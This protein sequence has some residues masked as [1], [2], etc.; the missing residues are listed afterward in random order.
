M[1]NK[2]SETSSSSKSFREAK[3]VRDEAASSDAFGGQGHSRTARSLAAIVSDN[4]ET[5][6]AIG[7]EGKYGSGKTTVVDFTRQILESDENSQFCYRVFSFDL[8]SNQKE[9]L[10]RVYLEELLGWASSKDQDLL[11][12]WEAE[13]FQKKI[14]DRTVTIH[15]DRSQKFHWF[16]YLLLAIAPLIPLIVTWASPMAWNPI[17]NSVQLDAFGIIPTEH[18]MSSGRFAQLIFL[19]LYIS[20][21]VAIVGAYFWPSPSIEKAKEKPFYRRAGAAIAEASQPFKADKAQTETETQIIREEDPSTLEFQSLFR[22]I[23]G[24]IQSKKRGGNPVRLVLVFDNIDRLTVSRI[25]P[26]WAE[27]RSIFAAAAP[28]ASKSE[29]SVTAVVPYDQNLIDKAFSG[30]DDST[31]TA[32]AEL[33][34]KTFAAT[35]RVAPPISFDGREYFQSKLTESIGSEISDDE[36]WLVYRVFHLTRLHNAESSPQVITPRQMISFI[37]QFAV[38]WNE[39]RG[40]VPPGTLALYA[41]N[42]N[43][44]V[45]DPSILKSR[46]RLGPDIVSLISDQKWELNLS[47]IYYNVKT[48]HVVPLVM[49]GEIEQALTYG[50]EQERTALLNQTYFSD[51]LIEFVEEYVENFNDRETANY[52]NVLIG[53][54]SLSDKPFAYREARQSLLR[55]NPYGGTA[56]DMSPAAWG[57]LANRIEFSEHNNV[58]WEAEKWLTAANGGMLSEGGLGPDL[59]SR[60]D[61]AVPMLSE[62]KLAGLKSYCTRF[63]ENLDAPSSIRFIESVTRSENLD[64]TWCS[65]ASATFAESLATACVNQP[66]LVQTIAKDNPHWFDEKVA[67]AVAS[68]L[69]PA[70]SEHI[71]KSVEKSILFLQAV[72]TC[73]QADESSLELLAAARGKGDLVVLFNYAVQHEKFDTAAKSLALEALNSKSPQ[74]EAYPNRTIGELGTVTDAVAKYNEIVN[75]ASEDPS[76]LAANLADLIWSENQAVTVQNLASKSSSGSIFRKW[77]SGIVEKG[78]YPIGNWEECLKQL[79][80]A[81]STLSEEL[82]SVW[83]QAHDKKNACPSLDLNPSSRIRL[84]GL[85]ENFGLSFDSSLAK[86][87]NARFEGFETDDWSSFWV[88]SHD[89]IELFLQRVRSKIETLRDLAGKARQ[90]LLE[91]LVDVFHGKAEWRSE[92]DLYDV[93]FLALNEP[94]QSELCRTTMRELSE[95]QINVQL[96]DELKLKMPS[97]YSRLDPSAAPDAFFRNIAV[98]LINDAPEQL[99]EFAQSRRE[100]IQSAVQAADEDTLSLVAADLN[101][102]LGSSD[103]QQK[104]ILE[105]IGSLLRVNYDKL[106]SNPDEDEIAS[107]PD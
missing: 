20:Y 48:E 12:D 78:I 72:W 47:A 91:H 43:R 37:N 77:F 68:K 64:T 90:S 49:K 60:L 57:G 97:L 74:A 2:T 26:V 61:A 56:Q 11:R 84:L 13:T 80:F 15:A 73:Y 23:V 19:G 39:R 71:D 46:E 14:R 105:K 17:S 16:A 21:V 1:S 101:A 87:E 9:N 86:S 25:P 31:G 38:L 104:E 58:P 98:P 95:N 7:L 92:D 4:S 33:V 65:P 66:D 88:G 50:N 35:I 99:V 62:E 28:G 3:L 67:S 70:L 45:G 22:N 85:S 82:F 34:S 103:A 29:N 42:S 75:N 40:D 10:R 53:M 51:A 93:F 59:V 8:W 102:A 100:D 30:D 63:T 18:S 79:D 69:I 106:A 96:W 6:A 5:D 83:L 24:K 55:I 107:K 27:V 41:A 36:K 54:A 89:D 81:E 76:D 94:S 52:S 32:G 44:I